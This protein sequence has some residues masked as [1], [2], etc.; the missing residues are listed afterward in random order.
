[1]SFHMQ[2]QLIRSWK[3]PF[4][5]S[6]LKRPVSSVFPVM[7]GQFIRS[8]EFPTTSLVIA[9]VRLLTSVCSQMGLQ[10]TR[11][12][13][14]LDASWMSAVM[15]HL[16]PLCDCPFLSRLGH[17]IALVGFSASFGYGSG[18]REGWHWVKHLRRLMLQRLLWCRVKCRRLTQKWGWLMRCRIL[19]VTVILIGIAIGKFFR[20][21]RWS[22]FTFDPLGIWCHVISDHQI[23]IDIVSNVQMTIILPSAHFSLEIILLLIVVILILLLLILQSQILILDL[24]W[25]WRTWIV[26]IVFA[27]AR[28]WSLTTAVRIQTVIW[29]RWRWWGWHFV[30]VVGGVWL[31]GLELLLRVQMLL[32]IIVILHQ[33]VFNVVPIPSL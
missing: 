5:K 25:P 10:V 15:N 30:P 21:V 17:L 13:V 31:L 26:N 7:S 12:C 16:F 27:A 1:M 4:A 32:G 11:L 19:N 24:I 14:R 3:C 9:D 22:V 18:G 28:W 2:R 33:N 29:W 8:G 23:I 20:S 6:A